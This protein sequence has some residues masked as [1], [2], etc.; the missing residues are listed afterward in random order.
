MVGLCSLNSSSL[1]NNDSIA[2]I[3]HNLHWVDND[4]YRC[5]GY[6]Q[7]IP[8]KQQV[9][10]KQISIS[11]K[12]YDLAENGVSSLIGSVTLNYGLKQI[13][14]NR[15]YLYHDMLHKKLTSIHLVNGLQ[16]SEPSL[17]MLASAGKIDFQ[18]K[19][20]YLTDV[21][22]RL[23][24]YDTLN[25]LLQQN[26]TVM[27]AKSH[28]NS[29]NAWGQAKQYSQTKT[30]IY[31][32]FNASY[33]TCPVKNLAW[34]VKASKIII[35][36]NTGKGQAHNLLLLAHH[37]PIFYLPYLSFPLNGQRMSGF[38]WPTVGSV[39]NS[40]G[41]YAGSYFSS[42][43]YL[44]LA[45]N[46]D[47]IITPVIYSKRGMQLNDRFRYLTP[48]TVGNLYI[49]ILPNDL[50]FATFKPNMLS[51]YANSSD[52]YRQ[53]T[54][55]RL[56]RTNNTR[57]A[58]SW[59]QQSQVSANIQTNI[60]YNYVSDDYFFE[61]FHSSRNENL[62][63]QLLQTAEVHYNNKY[64]HALARIAGYQ[65]LQPI[66][67]DTIFTNQYILAPQLLLNGHYHTAAIDYFLYSEA[68]HFDIK[69]TPGST[70]ILPRGNRL[71]VQPGI[72]K[73]F[74]WPFFY[75]K[76][77]AQLALTTYNLSSGTTAVNTI[78]RSM[79]I[80][81]INS[82][83]Y[84]EHNLAFLHKQYLQTITPE[85]YYVYIPYHQQNAIPLF[86]TTSNTMSYA[87]LFNYNRFSGID[88]IN[89]ANQLSYSLSSQ[90]LDPKSGIANI[91][92]AI[93]EILYFNKRRVTLYPVN[94]SNDHLDNNDNNKLSAAVAELGM[95]LND[96]WNI[97]SNIIWDP[98]SKTID[99]TGISL[100]YQHNYSLLRLSFAYI[101][102]KLFDKT[103][104]S[105]NL[106]MNNNNV[107]ELT[108][109]MIRWPLTNKWAVVCNWTEDWHD[110]H[111]QNLF[112]GLQYDSCCWSAQF[113]AGRNL[114][115]IQTNKPQYSNQLYLQIS[116]KGLGAFNTNN[117][118]I[119]TFQDRTAN[120]QS[121]F[122]QDV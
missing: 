39:N 38:L 21:L 53:A 65:T 42:P 2:T 34:Q 88:R 58:L 109:F 54:L 17:V 57:A 18:N 78:Q 82:G 77:R 9:A 15:A 55:R 49:S 32:F 100:Q 119:A 80:F 89:D 23:A 98:E 83:L 97:N 50:Y 33:S 93:G 76:P 112:Y 114:V 56:L 62:Q 67:T 52:S 81:E 24:I 28:K 47:T 64:W 90:I 69:Q 74:N 92:G 73:S 94:S 1:S 121:S 68:T 96:V 27:L 103:L 22:Y 26:Q 44:N 13:I 25:K 35:N 122:D 12:E 95:Q 99:N 86:D 10:A 40:N 110:L 19:Q 37:V 63:N 120:D 75:I 31:S 115:K 116:L 46:Y 16:I 14:A 61:D 7:D 51:T 70:N 87:Q 29:L 36:N 71:H 43:I 4:A 45:P 8:I 84:L 60:D 104:S 48:N 118:L 5:G 66:D 107:L 113:V 111:F 105:N 20:T 59:Q 106:G 41:G 102:N 91:H 79:P 108:D 3:N 72:E 6:Y 117:N 30:G 11:S 85:L 101:S